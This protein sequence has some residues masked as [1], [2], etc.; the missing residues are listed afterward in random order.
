MKNL[1][2]LTIAVIIVVGCTDQTSKHNPESAKSS[3]A[4]VEVAK[5]LPAEPEIKLIQDTQFITDKLKT[6]P[7][8]GKV[9]IYTE[10]TD[11]NKL[12]G[13]PNQ[14]IGKLNFTDTRYKGTK[15][16]DFGTI[17]IFKNK[18]DL[19]AR[20]QYVESVTKGTPLLMYQFR[21]ENLLM[22]LP[23]EVTPTQAKEYEAALNQ[24]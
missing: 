15:A 20:Y 13:R 18:D 23:H 22:R 6:I 19:E 3:S 9:V 2:I 5:P 7:T 17:E 21:H 4:N 16:E 14:Y 8:L 24:M 1:F 11:P 10:D 12:L